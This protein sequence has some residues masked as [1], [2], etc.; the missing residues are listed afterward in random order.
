MIVWTKQKAAD[1]YEVYQSTKK[2]GNYTMI[3]DAKGSNCTTYTKT[4]QTSNGTYYYKVRAYKT[5][6]GKKVYG[7]YSVIKSIKVK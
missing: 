3:R 5:I 7:Q 6:N 2:D 1:G 4:K